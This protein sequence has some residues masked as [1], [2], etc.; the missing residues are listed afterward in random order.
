VQAGVSLDSG[1]KDVSVK[2][3]ND[4]ASAVQKRLFA[5]GRITDYLLLAIL[6]VLPMV[7]ARSIGINYS[8]TLVLGSS[9]ATCAGY[10]ERRNWI[11]LIVLLP[12]ALWT[13]RTIADLLFC[14]SPRFKKHKRIPDLMPKES[15]ASTHEL[16]EALQTV[17]ICWL[18]VL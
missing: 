13:A 5:P 4:L 1:L 10:W 9:K 18:P 2:I 15:E 16:K 11:S 17:G 12:V 8:H 7:L 14:Q 3:V 6:A